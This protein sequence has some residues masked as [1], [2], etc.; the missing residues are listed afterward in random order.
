MVTLETG[1]DSVRL[2]RL[3]GI[4]GWP[5][6]RSDASELATLGRKHQDP[7]SA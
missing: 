4:D 6:R 3:K 5:R 7:L 1:C 2:V